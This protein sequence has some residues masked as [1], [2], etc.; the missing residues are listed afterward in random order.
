MSSIHHGY[1]V[2]ER[3]TGKTEMNVQDPEKQQVGNLTTNKTSKTPPTITKI[4][5]QGQ[6]HS[7]NVERAEDN[8]NKKKGLGDA[9][10]GLVLHYLDR[11]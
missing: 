9:S 3:G 5:T 8:N 7:G 11:D 4:P 1:C 2:P 6:N 10:S